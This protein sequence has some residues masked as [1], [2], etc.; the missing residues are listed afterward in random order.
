MDDVDTTT[1]EL[2]LVLEH[3]SIR[4]GVSRVRKISVAFFFGNTFEK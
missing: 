1:T 4:L 3:F 2:Y